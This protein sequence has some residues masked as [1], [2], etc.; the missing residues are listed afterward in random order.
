MLLQPLPDSAPGQGCF[1]QHWLPRAI[2]AA[3]AAAAAIVQTGSSPR[4]AE[5]LMMAL[6]AAAEN[7]HESPQRLAEKLTPAELA[8]SAAPAAGESGGWLE[9]KKKLLGVDLV[10]RSQLGM[11]VQ[12]GMKWPVLGMIWVL[13][14]VVP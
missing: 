7:F 1:G 5:Q 14:Q 2:A 11:H 9:E 4:L 3:A 10:K 8:V 12:L 6:L 13:S